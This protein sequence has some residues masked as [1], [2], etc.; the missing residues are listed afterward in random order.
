MVDDALYSEFIVFYEVTLSTYNSF[1]SN[2]NR[3]QV[4]ILN[5]L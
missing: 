1:D 5:L 4:A 3:T 2:F